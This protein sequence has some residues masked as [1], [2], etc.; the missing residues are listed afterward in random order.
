MQKKILIKRYAEAFMFY[1]GQEIGTVKLS[2]EIWDLNVLLEQNRDFTSFLQSHRITLKEKFSF[3]DSVVGENFSVEIRNFMRLLLVKGR[4]NLLRDICDRIRRAY[5]FGE[6]AEVLIKTAFP[7]DLDLI[8]KIEQRL[9][10]KFLKGFRF[11]IE[12]DPNLLGGVQIMIGNRV[13]DASVK[14]RL[15]DLRRGMM[16]VRVSY[17]D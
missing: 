6:R 4:F 2:E 13:I 3:L 5:L 12:L 1:A 10:E 7:L 17:D 11:Y 9:E 8:Q 14:R 16:K 15:D